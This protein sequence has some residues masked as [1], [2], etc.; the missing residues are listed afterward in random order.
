[1]PAA[2]SKKR[3]LSRPQTRLVVLLGK[4][5]G[6]APGTTPGIS[7]EV[8]YLHPTRIEFCAGGQRVQAITLEYDLGRTNQHIIDTLCPKG[9]NRQVEIREVDVFGAVKR[10]VAWGK[11][12]TQPAQIDTTEKMTFI[13]RM[14]KHL[15]GNPLGRIPFFHPVSLT[16]IL[17]PD[18]V[19]L[20]R[21]LIFN[22]EVDEI[23]LANKSDKEWSAR[24]DCFVFFDSM[25]VN[26]QAARS[27]HSQTPEKWR[28]FEAVHTLCWMLNPDETYVKN[29]TRADC[30]IDLHE[31]D[32]NHEVLR[33]VALKTGIFLPEALDQLLTA[34]G[35][36]WTVD[37]LQ[38]SGAVTIRKLRFFL[39][40]KGTKRELFLNRPDKQ[41][42]V[43]KSHVPQLG[44][45]FD[46]AN[47]ANKVTGCSSR[48]QR[49]GTFPL[50]S[51]WPAA[52]DAQDL[53]ALEKDPAVKKAYPHAYRKFGLN[54]SAAWNLLRTGITFTDLTDHFDGDFTLPTCRKFLPCLSRARN[55]DSDK[56]ESRGVWAEWLNPETAQWETF[57][58]GHQV[59]EQECGIFFD[60]IP[61]A[62]YEAIKADPNTPR[63]RVTATIEGD[64][65]LTAVA[66]P[67]TESPNADDIELRLELGDKFHD[68]DVQSTS[69]FYSEIGTADVSNDA[70]ALDGYIARI[71]G[72][73]DSAELSVSAVL[74][75]IDHPEYE[76]GDLITKVN[77]R[78]LILSRNNP[79]PGVAEK[80]PQ[81]MGIVWNIPSGEDSRPQME[82]LLESFDEET[83]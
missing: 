39:R 27:Y 50:W 58:W 40:N 64:L 16:S 32:D 37:F 53:D 59:L 38:D 63:I 80:F 22:Q 15:F 68:K 79:I 70:L 48:K 17:V 65:K 35:A 11:L 4:D 62:L 47:L 74:E 82:L 81:I 52:H 28:I 25:S 9:I 36:S 33:N 19:E 54:E 12:A 61:P 18:I 23:I 75:G 66:A 83:L 26:T 45:S 41:L 31:L 76:I 67:T 1:M 34:F 49:E 44:I 69:I 43:T 42:V 30:Y 24:D 14:D 78:N 73:E 71:R 2:P 20:D 29:P 21:P 5:D 56:L 77:G 60:T 10:I 55:A 3:T 8:D 51:L 6:S 72:V 13:A 57:T 46:I 7:D